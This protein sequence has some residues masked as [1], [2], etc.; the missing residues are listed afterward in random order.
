VVREIN[1][2]VRI[3]VYVFLTAHHGF[4][5]PSEQRRKVCEIN[6]YVFDLL[7]LGKLF[8]SAVTSAF[9][10]HLQSR[11]FTPTLHLQR[12]KLPSHKTH[13]TVFCYQLPSQQP[14]V[15]AQLTDDGHSTL[16]RNACFYTPVRTAP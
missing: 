3:A 8:I 1:F 12:L 5:I 7:Y 15:T 2:V 4:D 11:T 14:I 6:T 10:R 13:R 16:L 9:Y